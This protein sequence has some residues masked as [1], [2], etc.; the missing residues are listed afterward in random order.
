MCKT[1]GP[2]CSSHGKENYDKAKTN[3]RENPT[4]E[5]AKKLKEKRR[6]YLSTP[7][8]Q[9]TIIKEY[10][11]EKDPKKKEKLNKRLLQARSDRENNVAINK[12]NKFY[13][14]EDIHGKEYALPTKGDLNNKEAGAHAPYVKDGVLSP[15]QYNEDGSIKRPEVTYEKYYS[16]TNKKHFLPLAQAGDPSKR[17]E[18][19]NNPGSQF[20]PQK[21]SSIQEL[22]DIVQKQRPGGLEGDD[23]DKLIAEGADPASFKPG[24]R[25]LKTPIGGYLGS[26]TTDGLPDNTPI[27]F[28]EKIPGS[29]IVAVTIDRK[30]KPK[31]SE[32]VLIMAKGDKEKG[33]ND[34]IITAHPGM[35]SRPNP[36]RD[37]LTR[38]QKDAYDAKEHENMKKLAQQGKLTIT[39]TTR[40]T[41][42]RRSKKTQRKPRIQPQRQTHIKQKES[43]APKHNSP[44][45]HMY[46]GGD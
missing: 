7:D 1:G 23:R 8:G 32:G 42:N 21:V 35:P 38:E 9:K 20:D 37:G 43:H 19:L 41:H 36:D 13:T 24:F 31:V 22:A 30:T 2:R 27:S 14:I 6:D 40:K 28:H 33:E 11:S 16:G 18:F 44:R 4:P 46:Q 5:N 26:M 17:Q 25:Y 3:Y 10:E 45:G 12:G 29:N 15:A 39:S 34:Y